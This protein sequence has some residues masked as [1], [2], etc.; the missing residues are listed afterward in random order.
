MWNQPTEVELAKIPRLYETENVPA[1]DKIIWMHFFLGGSDWFI[2]EYDGEDIFFGFACLNGWTDLAEW[3]YISFRE[4]KQLKVEAPVSING[5][6][7]LIPLEVDRDLNWI[8]RKAFNV[9]L[10]RECQG[11]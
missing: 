7:M 4:L 11:W 5:Q 1:K 3:G 10:I 6:R 8:S 2:A 9:P